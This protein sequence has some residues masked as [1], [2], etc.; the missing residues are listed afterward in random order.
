MSWISNLAEILGILKRKPT[1]AVRLK[2]AETDTTHTG[3][4][5]EIDNT[6]GTE[7]IFLTINS[8]TVSIPAGTEKRFYFGSFTGYTTELDDNWD[9]VNPDKEYE[10]RIYDN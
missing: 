9:S 8:I 2:I 7:R 5:A 4:S 6:D 1:Y 10:V 3:K